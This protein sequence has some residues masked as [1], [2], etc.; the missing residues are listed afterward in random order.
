MDFYAEAERILSQKVR[1]TQKAAQ[2]KMQQLRDSL[3]ELICLENKIKETGLSLVKCSILSKNVDAQ[4]TN[5]NTLTTRLE[6]LSAKKD[7]LLKEKGIFPEEVYYCPVCKDTGYIEANGK[8]QRCSC[9]LNIYTELLMGEQTEWDTSCDF[10]D[11]KTDL[12]PDVTDKTRYGIEKS[13]R[14]HM[15]WLFELCKDF[16][17]RIPDTGVKN[18]IFTGKTGL[19]KSF[20]CS[21]M[22]NELI[23][24]GVSVLY[25]K[26]PE[27][28]NEIT[29]N[30]NQELR[31]QLYSVQLLIIDDLGTEKQTDMRYSDLLE[32]LEKRQMLH[33]KFGY[34]T[35][36]ST[37]MDPKGLLSYYDERICS[38]LFGNYDL[39]RFVGED[40][41]L[42]KK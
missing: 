17:G 31:R 26:A 21:C 14:A 39:I 1:E 20:L 38:R 7:A 22:A 12:Y 40:I 8:R 9:F 13:P 4:E 30:N 42:I 33:N 32:I 10:T 19:G 37:N 24:R 34:A 6:E 23:R 11:F 36:I 35:V 15:E 27:M 28:F 3:P 18:M 29:F 25:I 16:T 41:R 5:K 2:G